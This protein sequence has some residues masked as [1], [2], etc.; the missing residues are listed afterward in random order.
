MYKVIKPTLNNEATLILTDTDSWLL[1]VPAES[2]DE[3]AEKLKIVMDFSNYPPDHRLF[4]SQYKN[5][6][7]YLKNELPND[8]ILEVVGVR[9]KTYAIRTKNSIT[10]RCKG[11]KAYAKNKI[12]FSAFVNC[13]KNLDEVLVQQ[14]TIQSKSH[15]NRLMKI[16]KVAFSSFDDKRFLLCGIHSVPYGSKYIQ[17]SKDL[18]QCFM[19]CYPELIM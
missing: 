4:S 6:P 1:A 3:V 5:K 11:V 12:P 8:E 2:S 15:V 16:R 7:G 10:S 18:N 13:V 19:C 14:F 17:L 9:S